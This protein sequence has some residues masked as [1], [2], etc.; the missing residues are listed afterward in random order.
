M[1]A[2]QTSE[3]LVSYHKTTQLHYAGDLNLKKEHDVIWV[4]QLEGNA[5]LFLPCDQSSLQ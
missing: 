4:D 2:A 1:E 3:M 5:S